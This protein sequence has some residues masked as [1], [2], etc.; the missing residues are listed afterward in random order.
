VNRPSWGTVVGA[1]AGGFLAGAIAIGLGLRQS[2]AG[3]AAVDTRTM[4]AERA[5]IRP[6]SRADVPPM[7]APLASVEE[8]VR[9]PGPPAASIG[10]E[11]L[12]D[13]R[14]RQLVIPVKGIDAAQLQETFDDVRGAGRHEAIDILA[15]HD[16]P[17][18]AVEDGTVAKLFESKAGG[19]TLYQF[20]PGLTYAYYYAH[21]DRY[22]AGVREGQALRR[23][24]V[25]GYV[26]TSGNA[27][28]DTPHL[29]FAIFKLTEKKQW[30]QGAPIDPFRV[31]R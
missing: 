23:G 13:L 19:I 30:W 3:D 14:S 5:P 17:V 22:A 18:V 24:E 11:P 29:H 15:P 6:A 21:L 28:K 31:W 20:D 4:A 25:I 16:T 26:G 9:P 2:P 27:P 10:A 12:S 8:G 1:I 7:P